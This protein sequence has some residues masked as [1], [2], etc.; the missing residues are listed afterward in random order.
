MRGRLSPMRRCQLVGAARGREREEAGLRTGADAW[1]GRLGPRGD[2]APRVTRSPPFSA[3]PRSECD[4]RQETSG[5]PQP[6]PTAGVVS[7]RASNP[8]ASTRSQGRY[9]T[10]S[11]R[12]N[13][14]NLKKVRLAA[15]LD[16]RPT[17]SGCG[18]NAHRRAQS[19]KLSPTT[20]LAKRLMKTHIVCR[21]TQSAARLASRSLRQRL[22]DHAS[23]ALDQ[24]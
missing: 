2:L 9:A 16:V 1:A 12:G 3:M 14:R 17:S 15:H 22:G 6:P 8:A 24:T 13:S 21:L 10:G 7:H 20:G 19:L 5:H 4:A 18:R 11:G 23:G